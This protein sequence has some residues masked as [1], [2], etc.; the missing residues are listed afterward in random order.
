VLSA[1]GNFAFIPYYPFWTLLLIGLDI[2]I[3]WA[4]TRS[5][6]LE[7]EPTT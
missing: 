1:I 6:L 5:G 3:I 2:Y 4:L 7:R